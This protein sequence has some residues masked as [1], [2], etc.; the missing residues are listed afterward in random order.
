M[1][2]GS[3][4]HI[5]NRH[6]RLIFIV[7]VSLLVPHIQPI[8]RNGRH[9][10]APTNRTNVC[11]SIRIWYNN[12]KAKP[13]TSLFENSAISSASSVFWL[14]SVA[15]VWKP[16]NFTPFQTLFSWLIDLT[17]EYHVILSS[18]KPVHSWFSTAVGLE[19]HVI[20][21]PY[22][23]AALWFSDVWE[24]CNFTPLQIECVTYKWN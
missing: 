20:L 12:Y 9:F 5:S 14:E 11:F 18:F 17:F 4:A 16:C 1:R 24:P 13:P 15:C 10:L 7:T 6:C 2:S 8:P 23:T 22:K 3:D 21:L 19:H